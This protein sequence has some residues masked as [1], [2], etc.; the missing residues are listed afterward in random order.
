MHA[1]KGIEAAER[2]K[3]NSPK[4]KSP[5]EAGGTFDFATA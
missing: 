1:L 5:T 4:K 3:P 2:L